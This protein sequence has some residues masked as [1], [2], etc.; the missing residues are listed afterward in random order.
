MFFGVAHFVSY[1]FLC[2]EKLWVKHAAD[3]DIGKYLII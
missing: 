3:L 2:D 1:A